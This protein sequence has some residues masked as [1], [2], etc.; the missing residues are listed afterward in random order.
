MPIDLGT[1]N[2]GSTPDNV[3][4]SLKVGPNEPPGDTGEYHFT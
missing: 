3:D 1:E 4:Y 2:S